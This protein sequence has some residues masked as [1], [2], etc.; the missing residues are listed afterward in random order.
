M[1]VSCIA[2]LHPNLPQEIDVSLLHHLSIIHTHTLIHTHLPI[3]LAPQRWMWSPTDKGFCLPAEVPRKAR[4]LQ[5]FA[6]TFSQICSSVCLVL[7]LPIAQDLA[8]FCVPGTC[9][10]YQYQSTDCQHCTVTK[11]FKCLCERCPAN[12]GPICRHFVPTVSAKTGQ[13]PVCVVASEK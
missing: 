11:C 12:P 2:N 6:I 3:L 9:E 10:N 13:V 8:G 4:T 1:V 5:R 7:A